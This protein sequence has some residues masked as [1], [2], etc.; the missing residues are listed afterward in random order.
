MHKRFFILA[1]SAVLVCSLGLSAVAA[2][3]SQTAPAAPAATGIDVTGTQWS[4]STQN[5]KLAFLYGAS[6]IIAIE[7]L[8]AQEQGKAP[9]PF[10]KAWVS[11]FKDTRWLDLQ[12][13]LDDWYAK[14]P[15]QAKRHVFDV[16]WFEFMVPAA[17][18]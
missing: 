7:Q 6:S 16:L 18:K 11:A 4:Q 8:I 12:K 13:K 2:P 1:C 5:E 14:H 9:S 17:G 10:V 3:T 15:E